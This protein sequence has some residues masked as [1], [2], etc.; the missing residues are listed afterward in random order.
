LTIIING[1]NVFFTLEVRKALAGQ[2][3]Q[4][5]LSQL[6]ERAYERGGWD[7]MLS[8]KRHSCSPLYTAGE[9]P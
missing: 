3:D 4:K 9:V 1:N 8:R 6:P 2:I 7:P 5:S